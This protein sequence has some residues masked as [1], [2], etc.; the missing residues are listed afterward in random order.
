MKCPHSIFHREKNCEWN[1]TWY[2]VICQRSFTGVCVLTFSLNHFCHLVKQNGEM[3]QISFTAIDSMEAKLLHNKSH[4]KNQIVSCLIRI[5]F[6]QTDKKVCLL[7][8]RHQ[9]MVNSEHWIQKRR[10]EWTTNYS[11]RQAAQI[12][13]YKRELVKKQTRKIIHAMCIWQQQ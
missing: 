3:L 10:I 9:Q 6:L 7:L 2:I 12:E 5:N 13:W 11:K 4:H 1:K 8:H